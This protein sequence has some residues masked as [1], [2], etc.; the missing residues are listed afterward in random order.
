[1][2]KHAV[3][4]RTKFV[5]CLTL[6][7]LALSGCSASFS[8]GAPRRS[9]S[10]TTGSAVATGMT[11]LVFPSEEFPAQPGTN[12]SLTM[13]IPTSWK[14]LRPSAGVV[15]VTRR[16]AEDGTFMP[17]VFVRVESRSAGF[18]VTQAL[19]DLKTYAATLAQ[20]VTATPYRAEI[21]GRQFIGCDVSWIHEKAGALTQANLFSAVPSGSSV[22]LIQITG[23][24]GRA[25]AARDYPTIKAIMKSLTV[26]TGTA[27]TSL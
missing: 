16:I 14:P 21:D 15:M 9:P 17:N 5:C 22:Q 27:A 13:Q 3:P 8:V 2:T 1:M 11:R 26:G 25:Q 7:A 20:G 23:S 12:L 19:S 24:V 4:L 10:Q 6:T 18:E